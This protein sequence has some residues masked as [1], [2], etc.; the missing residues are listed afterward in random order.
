RSDSIALSYYEPHMRSWLDS[1]QHRNFTRRLKLNGGNLQRLN[2]EKQEL[3]I[4]SIVQ[5]H[6]AAKLLAA[7]RETSSSTV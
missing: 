5:A 7:G 6:H 3:R 1:Y 2:L 4:F